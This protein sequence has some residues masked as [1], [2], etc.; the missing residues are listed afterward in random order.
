MRLT[1]LRGHDGKVTPDNKMI[2]ISHQVYKGK[3]EI[4][5]AIFQ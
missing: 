5:A 3:T 4:V 1:D 2:F